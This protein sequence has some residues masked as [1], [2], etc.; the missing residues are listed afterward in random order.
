VVRGGTK[1]NDGGDEKLHKA[2]AEDPLRP[3]PSQWT[4]NVKVYPEKGGREEKAAFVQTSGRKTVPG[5]GVCDLGTARLGGVGHGLLPEKVMGVES[6]NRGGGRDATAS[7]RC[8][9]SLGEKHKPAKTGKAIRGV[10]WGSKS[11][12]TRLGPVEAVV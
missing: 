12:G 11:Q 8:G 7:Q 10:F 5:L 9:E 1:K 3:R 4:Q 6:Y 2:G